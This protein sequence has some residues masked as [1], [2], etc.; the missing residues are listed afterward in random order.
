MLL[1][2]KKS[3]KLTNLEVEAQNMVNEDSE[4]SDDVYV[5]DQTKYLEIVEKGKMRKAVRSLAILNSLSHRASHFM[6]SMS[7]KSRTRCAKR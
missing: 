7:D 5:T 4:G 6:A 1:S 2:A 3:R